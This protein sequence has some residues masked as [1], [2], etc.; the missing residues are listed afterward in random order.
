MVALVAAC[1]SWQTTALAA[2][3]TFPKGM[4]VEVEALVVVVP[5]QLWP[6]PIVLMVKLKDGS[7]VSE[8]V[9]PSVVMNSTSALSMGLEL[10]LVLP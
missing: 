9:E 1:R 2:A 7:T 6:E 5:L 8:R 4:E 10:Q 3:L